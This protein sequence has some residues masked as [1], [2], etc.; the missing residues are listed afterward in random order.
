VGKVNGEPNC[1]FMSLFDRIRVSF[2]GTEVYHPIEWLK[3]K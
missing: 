2:D 1:N 3:H